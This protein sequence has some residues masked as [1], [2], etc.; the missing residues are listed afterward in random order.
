MSLVGSL[1]G[2]GRWVVR[3]RL[4]GSLAC[5]SLAGPGLSC[6]LPSRD[7]GHLTL[8]VS[9]SMYTPGGLCSSN[10]PPSLRLSTSP[11][12]STGAGLRKRYLLFMCEEAS[13]YSLSSL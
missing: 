13:Q 10:L 5:G 1:E 6:P 12:A 11:L 3:A 4:S 9:Y 2:S 8:V 7:T